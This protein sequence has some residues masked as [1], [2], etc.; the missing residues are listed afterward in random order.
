MKNKINL[1]KLL[2]SPIERSIA[3]VILGSVVVPERYIKV[4]IG[5]TPK[6]VVGRIT[7]PNV[8]NFHVDLYQLSVVSLKD[9]TALRYFSY[10]EV[11]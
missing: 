6:S 1:P 2:T 9:S 4:P 10:D 7:A 5:N 3:I 11:D 8:V